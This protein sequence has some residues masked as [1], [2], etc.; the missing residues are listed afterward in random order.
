MEKV[1]LP[2]KEVLSEL[3]SGERSLIDSI[4]ESC[5]R[6]AA[7]DT[8]VQALLVEP[9]RRERLLREAA[10]LLQRYPAP[11]ARPPVFGALVCVKDL[12]NVDGFVTRAGSRLPPELFAGPESSVVTALR[13]AGA[14]VFGKT[15]TTEFAYFE[16]GPTRNP[17]NTAHTPGGSSS[18][19]AAAVAANYCEIAL[20]TQT[21]GSITRPASYCGVVGVKPSYGR[22]A[23]D[24]LV[25]FS[26][27]VDTV[28]FFTRDTSAL[29]EVS[30]LFISDWKLREVEAAS[31]RK[32]ALGV[33][34]GSYLEQANAECRANFERQLE[35]F[36][37]AGFSVVRV[38]M[39]GDISELNLLHRQLVAAE[40]AVVHREWFARHAELY[41]KGS[42]ELFEFGLSVS[43]ATLARA[44][45]NRMLLRETL[46]ARAKEN[47]VDIWL[48]PSTLDAA[49]EGIGAT[50]SPLMNLPWTHAGVPTISLPAGV[51][52]N[53]LP[54]GL[55]FAGLFGGDERLLG[56]VRKLLSMVTCG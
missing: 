18:G 11:A 44:R 23:G 31:M 47:G 49:P 48:S 1:A 29:A 3:R 36:T 32:P 2:L 26:P 5:A 41:R 10:E 38:P 12:F 30:S 42:R 37:A 35:R 20:G 53:G 9:E 4:E 50:G 22:V 17:R 21:I 16:P 34:V 25:P 6:A 28:G 33:P 46:S 55:Q 39:F 52:A 24:G 56:A 51:A 14:L 40:F 15:V 7:R 27:A 45:E 13:R 19:S 54:F 8:E 43:A